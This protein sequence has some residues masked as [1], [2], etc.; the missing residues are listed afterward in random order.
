M[1]TSL[2]RR[3]PRPPA[4]FVGREKE[5]LWVEA[6]LERGSVVVVGGFAGIGKTALLAKYCERFTADQVVCVTAES[7]RSLYEQ[8]CAHW[9]E[10][11]EPADAEGCAFAVIAGL[12]RRNEHLLIEDA[13]RFA[14]ANELA[15]L[16]TRFA[17]WNRGRGR[18]LV[19][20]RTRIVVPEVAEQTLWLPPLPDAEIAELLTRCATHLS[21][22]GLSDLV[23]RAGGNPL[24]ARRLASGGRGDVPAPLSDLPS[25]SL[26]LA[27]FL[28][29]VDRLPAFA[30]PTGLAEPLERLLAR[31]LVER[32]GSVLHI[33]EANKALLG[34]RAPPPPELASVVASA[35]V[36]AGLTTWRW[37]ALLLAR[38]AGRDDLIGRCLGGVDDGF[39]G[40][41]GAR[42]L[43]DAIAGVNS[44]E[45]L[46]ARMLCVGSAPWPKGMAWLAELPVP[47]SAPLKLAYAHALFAA[48]R[49]ER[50]NAVFHEVAVS[51]AEADC[52]LDAL[53]GLAR[54]ASG[55]ALNDISAHL[56]TLELELESDR[57]RRDVCL[58]LARWR[59]GGRREAQALARS[60]FARRHLLVKSRAA[61][62]RDLY[63]VLVHAAMFAEA[64][65]LAE[66]ES[67][68]RPHSPRWL[69][70]A[71]VVAVET[72]DDEQRQRSLAGLEHV[73]SGSMRYRFLVAYLNERHAEHV[74]LA[75]AL[76]ELGEMWSVAQAVQDALFL[77]D[78]RSYELELAVY[79]ASMPLAANAPAD[80]GDHAQLVSLVE[81]RRAG[82]DLGA[83]ERLGD[84][85]WHVV[86]RAERLLVGGS[87]SDA[88]TLLETWAAE[89]H[90]RG[91]VLE[92]ADLRVAQ[93]HMLLRWV[94]NGS[95]RA[96]SVRDALL[97]LATTHG[98]DEIRQLAMGMDALLGAARPPD[99]VIRAFADG[100]GLA[101][102]VARALLGVQQLSW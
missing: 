8:L 15:E 41:V 57:L 18:L 97:E 86:L 3:V 62:C 53:I 35:L 50:A 46:R 84:G 33:S 76:S 55:Q 16:V 87:G 42:R 98:L 39:V 94:G 69:Y 17:K 24:E 30:L 96:H 63:Q 61:S 59:A 80:D 85:P 90:L 1:S 52:R 25:E 88:D 7:V 6:A 70:Y 65:C 82:R 49:G 89:A 100:R 22:G 71:A 10:A 79:L 28:A 56:A 67:Y 32:E 9:G 13:H 48:N 19:L 102:R 11:A 21:A 54:G 20:G 43:F 2:R 36:Q 91:D 101:A 77:R 45:A 75:R 29:F 95:A 72:C 73:A 92:E 74:D 60:V 99:A 34:D 31:Q 83:V 93:A 64:R 27:S 51:V 37:Q 78:C 23:R 44:D 26:A 81:L 14:A 38:V 4:I 5:L 12:E 68:A 58:A 66:E 47:T 40:L